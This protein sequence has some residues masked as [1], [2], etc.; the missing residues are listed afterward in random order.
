MVIYH[1]DHDMA[2]HQGDVRAVLA[3][4]AADS[5]NCI[6][7]SPPYY[8][9][10]DYGVGGQIGLEASPME[11]VETMRTVFAEARRVLT[12]DGVLWLNL[13]D[14]YSTRVAVRASSHQDGLN[15]AEYTKDW[16][17]GK[18]RGLTRMPTF[19]PEKNLM[20]IPWRVAFA[21]QDDGWIL[22][23]DIIWRKT[24]GMPESVTDRLANKHEYL[25][26]FS[27]SR[28]YWFDL[29]SIREARSA[30]TEARYQYAFKANSNPASAT[31][32]LADGGMMPERI[33]AAATG[34]KAD[35]SN[36]RPDGQRHANEHPNGKNPGDVWSIPTA[37]FPGA[38]F[39][40][41]P[42]E[43]PRRCIL[44]GCP[45][46]S[47]VLDPFTGSGTT[48]MVARQL[49]RKFVG[50]EL[51]PDYCDLAVKRIGEPVLEFKATS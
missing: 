48:G 25:F 22:R 8:G 45:D 2:L 15:G 5:V 27:K 34:S 50:I 43:I 14:T 6:V 51:N 18:G 44:A 11:Y 17:R 37:P 33:R 24:N 1:S 13:G 3:D 21:L 41:F 31:N 42:P 46:G 4:M 16:T 40:T 35:G 23:N 39:A 30:A 26:L 32:H 12:D 19:L 38:H 29:D 9:L 49:G 10:R 20:G 7:T 28:S 47:T 36:L